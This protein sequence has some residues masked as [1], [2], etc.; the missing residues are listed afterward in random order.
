MADSIVLEKAIKFAL[1]VVN[2]YKYLTDE[3]KE[4]VLS[5]QLLLSA[6]YI[7]KY[8][9][10]ALHA[11]SKQGFSSEMYNA[12]G[13]ALDSELWLMLLNAGEFLSEYQ[14]TSLNDD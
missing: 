14:Y 1:R 7:A 10:S 3:K 13:R 8:C 6:A 12:L 11:R 5:K 9:K 4:Y 2:V